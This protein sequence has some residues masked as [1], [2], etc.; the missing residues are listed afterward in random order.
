[1]AWHRSLRTI[2][3][4]MPEVVPRLTPECTQALCLAVYPS[5]RE[6]LLPSP[7]PWATRAPSPNSALVSRSFSGRSV[8]RYEAYKTTT[9][10]KSSIFCTGQLSERH[11]ARLSK[12]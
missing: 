8:D 5:S 11:L 4:A 9:P 2:P 12:R 6:V 3:A 7:S 1:M 10:I